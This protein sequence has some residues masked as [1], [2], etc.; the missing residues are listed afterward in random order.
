MSPEKPTVSNQSL[1]KCVYFRIMKAQFV[2]KPSDF[3]DKVP[4][5]KQGSDQPRPLCEHLDHV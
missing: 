5:E 3:S 4:Y 1:M 2:K